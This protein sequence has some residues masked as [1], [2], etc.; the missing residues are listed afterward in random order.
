MRWIEMS[1]ALHDYVL[2][3]ANPR[4]DP[5]TEWLAAATEERFGL[6]SAMNIGGDQG[7]FLHLLVELAGATT[8]VEVGT[9]TGMSALWLARGLPAHGRLICLDITDEYLATAREAWQ[10]AGVS[11]RIEVRIG[12]A[13]DSL[14]AMPVGPHIDLAF[15]D[16][17]KTGYLDYVDLLLPRLT[18][19]AVI[20][21]DN[22]LWSG[23]VVDRTDRSES[24]LA[25][26]DF[27]DRVAARDDVDAF[28]LAI[29]DGITVIRPRR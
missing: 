12:P 27:N 15:V 21:V 13:A 6:L 17:D 2:D 16:A 29:G 18:E 24:T 28:M 22:V 4:H 7:R 23:Q 19:R 26:R 20:V 10:R 9:F 14:A 8:V 11:D 5:V 25:L 3:H 1:D